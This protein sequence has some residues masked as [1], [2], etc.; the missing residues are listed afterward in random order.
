MTQI[1]TISSIISPDYL[2]EF[3]IQ[4]YD[5]DANTTCSVLKT[6]V[7]HSYLITSA[8][9]KFVF[10]V[11]YVNW[12]TTTEIEEELKLLNYLKENE[13]G[14]SYPIK[15]KNNNYIQNINACEGNRFAVLFSFAEGETVRNPSEKICY[16]LGITIAKMHLLNNNKTINRINYNANTLINWAFEKA[17]T[18]FPESSEEM[19]YFKRANTIIS[20]EFEKADAN[21]LRYGTVH[22]D[23]W[24]ENMK[25]KNETDFTLFDFDNC[26]NGWLFLDISYTLMLLFRN[27][28]NKDNFK[29]KSDSFY[30]GYE[31]ITLISEEEKRLIPYGGLAIWLHYTGVHVERFND[32]SNPF[33]SE[34]FLKYWIHTLN[35]WMEFNN[36]KI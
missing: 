26:G 13:I 1:P 4:N 5:L 35:Q 27:E 23:L 16:N 14:V 7:N 25:V 18:R 15:D 32:F 6:G 34:E 20:H 36:I 31:S 22:L 3:V 17:K 29:L 21:S 11:Y 30:K 8:N 19:Q 24:Y 2:A 28:P 33:L 9:Q 12:R 10:R